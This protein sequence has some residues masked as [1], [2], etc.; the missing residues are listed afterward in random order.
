VI[1]VTRGRVTGIV[2]VTMTTVKEMTMTTEPAIHPATQPNG[3]CADANTQR[4]LV[5]LSA[6][7]NFVDWLD[8]EDVIDIDDE[9]ERARLVIKFLNAHVEGENY[10]MQAAQIAE[11]LGVP[12]QEVSK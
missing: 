6:L 1:R 4:G 5:I 7:I 2:G 10:C 3:E 8:R 9:R 12:F 11:I